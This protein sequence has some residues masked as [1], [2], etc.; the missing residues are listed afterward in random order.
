MLVSQSILARYDMTDELE[1]LGKTDFDLNPET[2]AQGYVSDDAYIYETGEPILDRVELW[3]DE[4]G[5]PD[6]HIVHKLPIRSRTGE[7]IGIMGILQSY[8]GAN[9][10]SSPCSRFCH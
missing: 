2:M 9:G 1:M 5:I 8:R 7:I 6:W 3:F 4:Q 10:S